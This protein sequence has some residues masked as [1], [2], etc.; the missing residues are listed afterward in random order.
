[1][2]FSKALK[3]LK[4]MRKS[5]EHDFYSDRKE[6][7]DIAIFSVE[8]LA[9]NEG[10]TELVPGGNFFEKVSENQFMLDCLRQNL[11]SIFSEEDARAAYKTFSLPERKTE[12]SA[13]YDFF[14]P[15]PISLKPNERIILPTG[16][17]VHIEK[18]FFLSMHIRSSVGIKH[19]IVLSNGTGIIDADYFGNPD[20]EGHIMFALWNTSD[21]GFFADAGERIAQGIF[22]PHGLSVFDRANGERTGG[23]GSTGE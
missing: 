1:M 4:A 7:L 2:N 17:K 9:R 10:R 13:G 8:H 12:N 20:N 6:A 11:N 14:L 16:V 5:A 15:L 19:G 18:G 23:I 22:L 21:K 3:E